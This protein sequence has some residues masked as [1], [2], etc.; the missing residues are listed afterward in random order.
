MLLIINKFLFTYNKKLI[1]LIYYQYN[2]QYNLFSFLICKHL[3]N[4]QI[5]LLFTENN[6]VR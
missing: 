4:E 2:Y 1:F 3:L 5:Y 6:F